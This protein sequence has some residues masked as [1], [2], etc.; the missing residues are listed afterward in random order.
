MPR[1]KVAHTD[2]LNWRAEVYQLGGNPSREDIK[3]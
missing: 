1:K 3:S 2:T